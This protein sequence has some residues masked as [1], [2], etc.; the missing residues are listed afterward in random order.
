M[1]SDPRHVTCY[2]CGHRFQIASRAMSLPCPK[3]HKVLIVEDVVVR[4]YKPVK[5]LSTCGR[6]IVRK[7]GRVV[8]Q[9]I[10]AHQ[11]VEC[12]G[13]VH[14]SVRSGGPVV[15]GARAEWKGDLAAPSLA[16]RSGA[17]VLG[18]HFRIPTAFEVPSGP[19]KGPGHPA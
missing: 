13:A 8:A 16:V 19:K 10:E 14:A 5:T 18:G 15:L 12:N 2:H 3:C 11:G 17:R 9:T 4:N 1:P 6:L 7:G